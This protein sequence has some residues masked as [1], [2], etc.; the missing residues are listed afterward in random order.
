MNNLVYLLALNRMDQVGPRT[1]MKLKERWPNL[2][3]L[4]ALSIAEMEQAGL[5]SRL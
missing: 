2:K 5:P 1:V 3:E 4:F